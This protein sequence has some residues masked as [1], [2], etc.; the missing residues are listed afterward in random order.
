MSDVRSGAAVEP[1]ADPGILDPDV[2]GPARRRGRSRAILVVAAWRVAIVVA[3]LAVWEVTSGWLMEPFWI[4]TPSRVGQRLWELTIS[5]A[6]WEHTRTTAEEAG[7][8]LLLGMVVGVL[9]GLVLAYFKRVAEILDPFILGLYSL[10]RVA[11][12]PLFLIW[13]G[14]GLPSKVL[15][16]FSIVVFVAMINTY[17]GAKNVDQD[18]IDLI[19]TMQGSQTDIARRVLLP[20]LMPWIMAT[21][22]ISVGLAL[23]GAVVGE[24]MG[25]SSGLGYYVA[26]SGGLFDTTGVM[27]GLVGL[28]LL[29][30]VMNEG[31]RALDRWLFKWRPNVS[32]QGQAT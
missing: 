7:L 19:K 14:I 5:G 29:A 20:S 2:P 11:L 16:A 25:S 24:M 30:V 12:A 15:L 3:F 22:R 18:L 17:E 9:A 21:L 32:T 28:G 26:R 8:G 6:L 1:E 23:V 4:S 31:V 27:A 13:F 10:P